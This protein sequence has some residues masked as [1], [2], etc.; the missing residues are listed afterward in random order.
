[1]HTYIYIYIYTYRVTRGAVRR[2]G[3]LVAEGAL[4]VNEAHHAHILYKE[5]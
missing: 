1:M 5:I 3:A 4:L 2:G